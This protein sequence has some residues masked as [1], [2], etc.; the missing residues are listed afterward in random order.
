MNGPTLGLGWHFF[1]LKHPPTTTAATAT[2]FLVAVRAIVIVF[3][4]STLVALSEA[5]LEGEKRALTE[6]KNIHSPHPV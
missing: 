4:R 6:K 3:I 5:Y 2:V 1:L